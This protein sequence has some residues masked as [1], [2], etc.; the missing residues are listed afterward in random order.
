MK[1][2]FNPY[3]DTDF[4]SFIGTFFLR[5]I[6]FIRG[7]LSYNNLA[8]DEIQILVLSGTAISAALAGCFLVLRKQTMVANSLSHT[9]LLGIIGA[10]F[11]IPHDKMSLDSSNIA[12]WPMLLASLLVALLTTFL[13][14]FLTKIAKLQ[15]DAS[16][17]IVFSSL[18]ALGIVLVTLLTR[19]AHIGAEVVMGNVDALHINDIKLAYII[20]SINTLIFILFYKEFLV[21]TFDQ[22][23]AA[24]IG[25]SAR[26]INYLLMTLVSATIIGAF[27]A[28]GVLMVLTF[29][30]GPA[31]TARLLSNSLQK[32]LLLAS[33]IGALA[34]FLGV[35][36]SRHLLSLYGLA[37]STAGVVVAMTVAVYLILIISKAVYS[38][39]LLLKARKAKHKNL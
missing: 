35:A 6:Q 23:Y 3:Y 15:E 34:S 31:L 7:E 33:L 10:F 19:D 27:R 38:R 21:T 39:R 2:Y 1:S 22:T 11:L 17:A 37:L 8:A 13:G 25:I 30:T 26:A 12:I 29:I 28:V 32:M 14:D 5:L 9:I 16:T 18:F 36:L 20:L 24:A 4:F